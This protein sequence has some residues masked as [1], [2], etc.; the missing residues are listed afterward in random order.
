[1]DRTHLAAG[2][3]YPREGPRGEGTPGAEQENAG[4]RLG[5]GRKPRG[6]GNGTAD[7]ADHADSFLF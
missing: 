3:C 2:A 1:M 5:Y 7:C 6:P 4:R